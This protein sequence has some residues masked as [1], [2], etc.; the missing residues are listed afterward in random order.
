MKNVI[1]ATV[2]A[3]MSAGVLAQ[4]STVNS[5]DVRHY[6][7]SEFLQGTVKKKSGEIISVPLNYNTLTEEMIF[8][9]D[10][11]KL[12]LDRLEEI[13]YVNV[14]GKI[15]VPVGKVFYE[16]VTTTP[17]ALYIEHKTDML[18]P[19]KEY[20]YGKIQTGSIKTVSSLI[21]SHQVYNLDV[22]DDYKLM[23]RSVYWLKKDDQYVNDKYIRIN[24]LNKI[25]SVF[26]Q[27]AESIKEFVKT[28]HIDFNN[29]D[30]VARLI[31]F[32]N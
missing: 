25:A 5:R 30:D 8:E 32:C 7:F 10:S 28:N 18:P 16:R 15:F 4:D 24:S 21:G 31:V 12:A 26:S 19:G 3:C 29:P 6:I 27:K 9:R 14:D 2:F 23:P 22:P 20:G 1:V 13:D 17:V 11:Q